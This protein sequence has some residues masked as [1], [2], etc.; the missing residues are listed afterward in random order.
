MGILLVIIASV[1][2]GIFPSI[3]GSILQNGATPLGLVIV[4]NSFA[5]IFALAAGKIRRESF[6]LTGRQTASIALT[7]VLGL[8]LT[9][10]LLNL[11]YTMIPVGFTTM[12]HFMYPT[13]VCIAMCVLFHEKITFGKI[14]AMIFS[15][16]GLVFISGGGSNGS[17][18]GILTALAT[19]VTYSFYMISNDKSA[20]SEVSLM[21]RSFYLNLFVVAAACIFA[22]IRGNAVFP[23]TVCDWGLSALVGAMLS[24]AIMLLNAGIQRLGAGIASFINMLEPV[25]SLIVSILV[26]RYQV[27]A[28]AILGCALIFVSL[29]LVTM[30]NGK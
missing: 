18:T 20:A 6:R 13:I 28:T 23:Q 22:G 25:T 3:Q 10:Y 27:T 11:T 26:F 15:I 4:C 30:K 29:F 2:F 14:G 19:A 24:A 5:G 17:F 8:F 9:D 12:I 21:A 1:M 16:A 7:G